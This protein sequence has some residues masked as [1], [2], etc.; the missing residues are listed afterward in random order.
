MAKSLFAIDLIAR[1][2]RGV[3]MPD[4]TP[5]PKA[6]TG[7]VLS[8]EDGRSDTIRPRAEAA[9]TDLSRLILPR[10][11]QLPQFPKDLP[12]L[13]ELIVDRAPVL[14]VIDPLFAF[15]PPKV[16]ANLDQCARLA[17]T[18]M[19]RLAEWTGCTILMLRHVNKEWRSRAVHRG[20]GS[21]AISAAARA[22]LIVDPHPT[23][24]G[25]FVVAVSKTNLGARPPSLGYR[26]VSSP[27]GQPVIEWTGPVEV[28]ADALGA[29]RVP[30]KGLKM[31]D[32]AV[33]W[34]SRELANGP[35]KSVD[36]H[37][38]AAEAGIPDRTLYR[39]KDYLPARSHKVHDRKADRSEW[40]WY[41][42]SAAWPKPAPFPKPDPFQLPPLDW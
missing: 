34:L 40:W 21:V 42:P 10:F 19:A 32:R 15:L 30:E 24:P 38:A 41:D 29:K 36:I 33:D 13:E 27:G 37:A 7:A 16:A 3:P 20:L 5:V 31:R 23:D 28:T 35:R 12:A 6:L 11:H 39:A 2:S 17:L 1:L 8:A 26:V 22:G 14:V 4:G 9:G 25:T 18:P